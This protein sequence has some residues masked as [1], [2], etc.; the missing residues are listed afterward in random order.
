MAL[1]NTVCA[2]RWIKAGTYP[3]ASVGDVVGDIGSLFHVLVEDK[4]ERM[5]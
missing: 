1:R 3:V 2:S 5:R 4:I